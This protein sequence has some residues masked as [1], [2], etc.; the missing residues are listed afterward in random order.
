[1][2]YVSTN[3]AVFCNFC[4]RLFA[5]CM[6]F[7]GSTYRVQHI[8]CLLQ[9]FYESFSIFATSQ[10]I[11]RCSICD[12]EYGHFCIFRHLFS[13]GFWRTRNFG[14]VAWRKYFSRTRFLCGPKL[15]Y[16]ILRSFHWMR[17]EGGSAN[18]MLTKAI[19]QTWSSHL[20][21]PTL[22]IGWSSFMAFSYYLCIIVR[23][24]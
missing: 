9:S 5:Y 17:N 4:E 16:Q 24:I 18:R 22:S 3:S 14:I 19:Q 11:S 2:W 21:T 6:F 23:I 13:L 15:V 8:F 7:F 12:R 20:T 1:M 10:V